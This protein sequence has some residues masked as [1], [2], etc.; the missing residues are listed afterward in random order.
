M[1]VEGVDS[2]RQARNQ[3]LDTVTDQDFPQDGDSEIEVI[4]V[5]VRN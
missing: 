5:E 2:P 3:A 4:N 1:V